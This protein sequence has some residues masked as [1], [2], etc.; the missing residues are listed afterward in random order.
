MPCFRYSSIIS[1]PQ[2][3]TCNFTDMRPSYWAS[4]DK[5]VRLT[6]YRRLIVSG[7]SSFIKALWKGYSKRSNVFALGTT[8]QAVIH[9]RRGYPCWIIQEHSQESD[10]KQADRRLISNHHNPA[11]GRH[12]G[13]P[14]FSLSPI[15]MMNTV[16]F[17]TDQIFGV[18]RRLIGIHILQPWEVIKRPHPALSAAAHHNAHAAHIQFP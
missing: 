6:G 16:F 11:R 4:S 15:C 7:S 9:G 5:A 12:C 2:V 8:D 14:L 18:P 3:E 13:N 10:N 1:A 17:F